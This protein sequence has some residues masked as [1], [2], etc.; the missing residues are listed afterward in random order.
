MSGVFSVPLTFAAVFL[1]N[2]PLKLL[3]AC[4][5]AL[6]VVGACY[7]VWRDSVIAL[8]AD[9]AKRDSEI[10]R[11]RYRA[12][13]DE[14]LRLAEKKVNALTEAGKDL[15]CF[16]LHH[17]EME[18]GELQGRCQNQ[19]YYEE[20]IRRARDERLLVATQRAIVGRT[21]VHLF[22]NIN[23]EFRTVLQDLLGRREARYFL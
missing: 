14:H 11:L 3:F 23:P 13:D 12:Y 17:G 8:Q 20:A 15:V 2:P 22:W 21:G 16:L 7:Q 5:A 4:L 19:A 9:I 18:N 1:Q 10:E 6:G